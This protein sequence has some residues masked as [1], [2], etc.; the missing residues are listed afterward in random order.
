[1]HF[2]CRSFIGKSEG[3]FWSRY[4][5]NESDD[6]S[7]KFSKGHLFALV[8]LHSSIDQDLNALGHSLITEFNQNYF[9]SN[10]QAFIPNSLAQSLETILS[11]P[12]FSTIEI[13]LVAVV[14][15]N[16]QLYS[17]CFGNTKLILKRHQQISILIDNFN[18]VP[19]VI[20][21]TIDDHDRLLLSSGEFFQQ[22]GWDN[23]KT[24]ISDPKIQS[25]EENFLSSLYSLNDQKFVSAAFIQADYD[26]EEI[27][28]S[29]D[30][31]IIPTPEPN[32]SQNNFSTTPKK[33]FLS[34][35]FP[36]FKGNTG[37]SGKGLFVSS[38]QSKQ[39]FRRSYLKILFCIISFL[40][41]SLSLFFGIRQSQ[42]KKSENS[43]QKLK[44]ELD[45]KIENINQLKSLNFDDAKTVAQSAKEIVIKMAELKV[46][47]EEVYLYQQKIDQF[48]AQTGEESSPQASFYDLTKI[49][50][51]ANYSSFIF[52]DQ[53][54][55]LLD[56]TNGR[57]DSL[58]ISSKADQPIS[59][60]AKLKSALDFTLTDSKFYLLFSD[61]ISLLDKNT[62]TSKI[63]F[64]DSSDN[65]TPTAFDIWNSAIYV[66]DST[67]QSVL[68]F[69]P[70]S[71]GFSKAQ[72]WL[73]DSQ[74]TAANTNS[75]SIDSQIWVLSSAGQVTPY[76]SGKKESFTLNQ[77]QNFINTTNLTVAPDGDYLAFVDNQQIVYVVKKTGELILK[78]N[79][80]KIKIAD[81]TLD[82]ANK[83]LYVLGQDQKIYSLNF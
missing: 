62:I 60:D 52:Q 3:G 34:S 19:Q 1:M 76:L 21:G 4:W 83:L 35:L 61:N 49:N 66:L 43:Y 39:Q 23:I 45:A 7:I 82:S 25:L 32:L 58:I 27:T 42:I 41:L 80:G 57:L 9:E 6:A 15:I 73:K 38:S 28:S 71:T 65:I 26:D 48:L 81:I 11:N 2:I 18:Q 68:K 14:V 20:N 36:F 37:S 79:L 67:N 29:L 50:K 70:N 5:E 54:L 44:V 64:A 17:F 55:Y 33:S 30:Q 77:T 46:N 56:H 53:K 40:A 16:H 72:T 74:K 13:D 63:K 59:A 22:I 51:D 78:S 12:T 24:F 8:N 10:P 47:S 31:V 69:N 75:I